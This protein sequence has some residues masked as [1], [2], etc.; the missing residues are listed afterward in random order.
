[1]K[2]KRVKRDEKHIEEI[3]K[4]VEIFLGEIEQEMQKILAKAS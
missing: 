2:I 1:M 3:N 4:A